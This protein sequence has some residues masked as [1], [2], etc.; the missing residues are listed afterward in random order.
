[1]YLSLYS[2]GKQNERKVCAP[3]MLLKLKISIDYSFLNLCRGN[4]A[5]VQDG[6]GLYSL[7][8]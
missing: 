8:L 3:F 2:T 4:V 6:N 7:H 5:T 1:M